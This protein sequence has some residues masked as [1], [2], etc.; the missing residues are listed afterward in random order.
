MPNDDA[1]TKLAVAIGS[2]GNARDD[3]PG[4]FS[5][6]GPL[7]RLDRIVSPSGAT[8]CGAVG[9]SSIGREE[10]RQPTLDGPPANRSR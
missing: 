2:T 10:R 8:D 7:K 3:R 4:I 5:E 1:T 6:S 9:A